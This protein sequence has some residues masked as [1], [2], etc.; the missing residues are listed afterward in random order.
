M[1]KIV[2][3][4]GAGTSVPA[5]MPKTKHITSKILSGE[6]IVRGDDD[7]YTFGS[8]NWGKYG[9]KE[10]YIW[11][12]K[13]IMEYA[14]ELA[15]EYYSGWSTKT[16]TYE[17]IY[18]IVNQILDGLTGEYTNPAV[19]PA[20]NEAKEKLQ[21]LL[22]SQEGEHKDNWEFHEIFEETTKYMVDVVARL[23]DKKTTKIQYLDF[24]KDIYEDDEIDQLDIFT[25]N[26]DLVLESFFQS[27]GITYNDGFIPFSKVSEDF[28]AWNSEETFKI[29]GRPRLYKLHGSIDWYRY[30]RLDGVIPSDF[31]ARYLS[32]DR[33]ELFEILKVDPYPLQNHPRILVGTYNKILDYQGEVFHDLQHCFYDSLRHCNKLFV[34]GYGFNDRS[35]NTRIIIW[36]FS[37]AEKQ[38]VIAHDN[39]SELKKNS[40]PAIS[41]SFDAWLLQNRLSIIPK[42]IDGVSCEEIKSAFNHYRQGITI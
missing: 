40:S 13:R 34:S 9:F 26:H 36:M 38:L 25:L 12:V 6:G 20:I 27:V 8:F 3:L 32:P 1:N 35:V 39:F 15:K 2:F 10:E 23:L 41:R 29:D 30:R 4:F 16:V 19:L 37:S 24:I 22:E 31:T 18:F 7:A 14:Q 21:D 11:R 17:D 33:R 28:K 42:M 5:G